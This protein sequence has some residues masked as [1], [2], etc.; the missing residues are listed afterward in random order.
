MTLKHVGTK[1]HTSLFAH[2]KECFQTSLLK[3]YLLNN[4]VINSVLYLA[5]VP[6]TVKYIQT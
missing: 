5:S 2:K 3:Y 1:Q 6:L 4:A